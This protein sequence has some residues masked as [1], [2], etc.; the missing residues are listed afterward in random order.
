[1]D[2][3]LLSADRASQPLPSAPMTP[4]SRS[5]PRDPHSE[6]AIAGS[7][8]PVPS[9]MQGWRS[10][11]RWSGACCSTPEAVALRAGSSRWRAV[12][13]SRPA[14]IAPSPREAGGRSG[15]G[16][17]FQLLLRGTGA[18]GGKLVIGRG[19]LRPTRRD[20]SAALAHG[21]EL[22]VSGAPSLNRCARLR[23]A[24]VG[25]STGATV[26]SWAK[27]APTA[28]WVCRG[29]STCGTCP[30]SSSR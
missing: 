18:S 21:V 17:L 26:V 3:R 14:D 30:H 16:S 6:T 9:W 23:T 27:N 8:M 24:V 11:R 1:M 20:P 19:S 15:R 25:P 12:A 22:A 4:P 13:S 2:R 5:E 29:S 7:K 10:G 28:S